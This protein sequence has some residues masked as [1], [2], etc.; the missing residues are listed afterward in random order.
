MKPYLV[1]QEKMWFVMAG[2]H[3]VAI[4]ASKAEGMERIHSLPVMAASTP[5]HANGNVPYEDE[6]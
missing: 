4:V 3:I 5:V 2:C 6:D 1:H